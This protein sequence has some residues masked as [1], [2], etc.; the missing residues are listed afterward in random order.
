MVVAACMNLVSVRSNLRRDKNNHQKT[1]TLHKLFLVLWLLL[2]NK[3]IW[4]FKKI[5]REIE[6]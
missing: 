3:A 1:L 6:K 4:K 2:K 5:A